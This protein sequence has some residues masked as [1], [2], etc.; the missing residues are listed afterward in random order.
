MVLVSV[1]SVPTDSLVLDTVTICTVELDVVMGTSDG[2]LVLLTFA[3][4]KIVED[5]ASEGEAVSDSVLPNVDV[6]AGGE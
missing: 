4:M 2:S 5:D 3:V 6:K 1:V